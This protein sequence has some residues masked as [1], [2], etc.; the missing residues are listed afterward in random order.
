MLSEN[1]EPAVKLVPEGTWTDEK[2]FTVSDSFKAE[3]SDA[4]SKTEPNGEGK[5]S[6]KD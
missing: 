4:Y 3:L 1:L 2:H 6:D 5:S